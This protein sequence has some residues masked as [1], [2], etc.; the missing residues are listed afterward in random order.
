MFSKSDLIEKRQYIPKVI[1]LKCKI[2][3]VYNLLGG[4]DH[5]LCI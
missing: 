5:I 3:T 2:I 1:T 4:R